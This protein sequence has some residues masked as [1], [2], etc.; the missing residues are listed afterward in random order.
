MSFRQAQ[1][2]KVGGDAHWHAFSVDPRTPVGGAVTPPRI[3]NR[4]VFPAPVRYSGMPLPRWWA[5]EDGRTNF[6]RS[7]RTAPTSRD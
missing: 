1:G 5:V 4:T 2:Q 3:I 6:A 7:A